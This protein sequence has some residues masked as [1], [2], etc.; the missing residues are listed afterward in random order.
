VVAPD[1]AC[2][3]AAS[4]TNPGSAFLKHL[5]ERGSKGVRL[6]TSDRELAEFF[7]EAAWPRGVVHWYRNIFSHAPFDQGA[8]YAQ[9]DPR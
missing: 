2:E 4:N 5:K 1:C 9:G 7:L 3:R 6:I 8:A